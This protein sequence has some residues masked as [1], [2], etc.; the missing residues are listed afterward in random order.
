[1]AGTGVT[2]PGPPQSTHPPEPFAAHSSGGF[3]YPARAIRDN[4]D[5]D[6][7]TR[8][9]PDDP[10]GDTLQYRQR[11][12]L[13]LT[14]PGVNTY[15]T[16][17]PGGLYEQFI[18][19]LYMIDPILGLADPATGSL[20]WVAHNGLWNLEAVS[21]SDSSNGM[22]TIFVTASTRGGW[23]DS[24]NQPVNTSTASSSSGP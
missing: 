6:W 9:D 19:Q 4:Y 17:A 7:E 21:C 10:N 11:I 18:T 23:V 14:V 20:I 2:T 16:V 13:S 24:N 1:M 15:S 22:S 5:V 12:V 8:A 3:L